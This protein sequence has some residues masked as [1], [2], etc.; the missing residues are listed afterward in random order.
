MSTQRLAEKVDE[1]NFDRR[2]TQEIS[3]LESVKLGVA[4]LVLEVG[5]ENRHVGQ[6]GK[7]GRARRTT[8]RFTK[9]PLIAFNFMLILSLGSVTFGEKPDFAE[10]I[11][12]LA[13]DMARPK[14]ASRDMPPRKRSKG[15]KI[16][17]DAAASKAKATK[18]PTTGGKGKRKGKDPS[19]ASPEAAPIVTA[20]MPLTSPLLRM[21]VSTKILGQ[22]ILSLR[23]MSY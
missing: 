19:P 5:V 3:R 14:V 13:E 10:C 2:W 20:S 18:L 23:M 1:P 6:F 21:R 8:R 17:E 12:R 22:P 7:L 11:L 15:I 4:G 16:N 9:S